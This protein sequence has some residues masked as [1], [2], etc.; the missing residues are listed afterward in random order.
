MIVRYRPLLAL[1][2]IGLVACGQPGATTS[3]IQPTSASLPATSAQSQAA[4]EISF[5][6]F[7]DP[8]EKQ[9]YETIVEAFEKRY[10]AVHVNLIHIPG[11]DDY[12]KRMAVDFAAG[13]PADV[14]LIS[15]RRF[16]ALA[17]KGALE[18]LGPYLDRSAQL[19]PADFYEQSVA[20]FTW[21]GALQCIPQNISSLVVYYNKAMFDRA[22]LPYPQAGW[23]WND[24]LTTAKQLTRDTDGDGTPNEYGL[25]T[26]AETIRLAPFIWQN[27]GALVNSEQQPT[28]LAIDSPEARAAFTWFVELQTVHHVA[29]D[30]VQE[31]AEDSESRFQNGRLG[32]FLQ[33]RR[34]VPG[35]REIQNFDWDVAPLPQGRQPAS[36]LHSDAYC[37]PATSQNKEAAWALIE[38]ANSPEGQ[39]IVAKTGRTVPS[40][41][42]VAESPAFLDPQARPASSRVFLEVIPSIRNTPIL[43]A[44][45]EIEDALSAEVE[46]AYYG[47]A[48]VD[49]A[50]AAAL[51]ATSGRFGNGREP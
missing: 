19:K 8:A 46:R 31:Q 42:A 23:T 32:M 21:R 4:G 45:P 34:V 36:I 12:R 27:G 43:P 40:L 17:E 50:I 16:A 26:T 6:V 49:E 22:G 14:L 33:S 2:L 48:S 3:P 38:F 13:S 35:L 9:A 39:T 7:G 47:Q 11:Q 25:G 44:W 37:L 30:S 18:P 15:Y 28:A 24:F 41:R 5:M 1:L 10:P 29:P 51:A 20:A